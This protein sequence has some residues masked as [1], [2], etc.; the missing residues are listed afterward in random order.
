MLA[1]IEVELAGPGPAEIRRFRQR[2]DLIRGL[3]APMPT[4]PLAT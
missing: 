3:L 1:Q 2:A 4:E